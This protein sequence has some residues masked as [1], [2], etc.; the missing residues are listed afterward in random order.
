MGGA[1][2]CGVGVLGYAAYK[3]LSGWKG[4][5]DLFGFELPEF[6]TDPGD[7]EGLEYTIGDFKQ[8]IKQVE[9][10]Y[11]VSKNAIP[12]NRKAFTDAVN[13]VPSWNLR[14]LDQSIIDMKIATWDADLT[15]VIEADIKRQNEEQR[16]EDEYR[17][18][19]I[20]AT[21]DQ[22]DQLKKDLQ[23]AK[24]MAAHQKAMDDLRAQQIQLQLDLYG[25]DRAGWQPIIPT[26]PAPTPIDP[27]PFDQGDSRYRPPPLPPPPPPPPTFQDSTGMT[28]DEF[29]DKYGNNEVDE[30]L[31][32]LG[33]DP[34]RRAVYHEQMWAWDH[35]TRGPGGKGK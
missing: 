6:L 15:A 1:L 11:K 7:T 10:A 2:I 30:Y 9:E 20:K 29:Q 5:M 13:L 4:P 23:H 17:N 28:W 16:I 19:Q 32:S 8:L 33:V 35:F 31:H 24:D 18:S 14:P 21:L 3:R 34:D 22:I 26:Y 25:T 12:P 27:E